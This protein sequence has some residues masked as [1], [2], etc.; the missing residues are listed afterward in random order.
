LGLG[1]GRPE[2]LGLD[3]EEPCA[4]RALGLDVTSQETEGNL[5]GR[6]LGKTRDDFIGAEEHHRAGLRAEFNRVEENDMC[7]GSELSGG[8]PAF[9]IGAGVDDVRDSGFGEPLREVQ[10][11][12]VITM[13]V[14]ADADPEGGLVT[15]REQLMAEIRHQ[16]TSP[17]RLIWS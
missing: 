2:R 11:G 10:A 14:V 6:D 3:A 15:K 17:R 13:A 5:V 9:G 16:M 8:D 12:G 4:S 7:E 1:R